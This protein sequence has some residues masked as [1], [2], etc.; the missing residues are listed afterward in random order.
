MSIPSR[1]A[2]AVADDTGWQE[3]AIGQKRLKPPEIPDDAVTDLDVLKS[4]ETAATAPTSKMRSESAGVAV[5][6]ILEESAT[7]QNSTTIQNRSTNPDGSYDIFYAKVSG[8]ADSSHEDAYNKSEAKVAEARTDADGTG[9]FILYRDGVTVSSSSLQQSVQ[10]VADIFTWKR[11]SN[12]CAR[13]LTCGIFNGSFTLSAHRGDRGRSRKVRMTRP[14]SNSVLMN[15]NAP[16]KF[17][18]KHH[19]SGE[20]I[21]ASARPRPRVLGPFAN[22]LELHLSGL[23]R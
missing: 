8:R 21:R 3:D 10:T 17:K 18:R 13:R 22:G 20:P 14:L 23:A 5:D 12:A 11:R 15:R 6:L 19:P 2:S 1:V 16:S 9:S 4:E 7:Y